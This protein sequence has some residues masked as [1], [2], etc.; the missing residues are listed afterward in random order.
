MKPGADF[1]AYANGGWMKSVEIPADRSSYG[2]WQVLAEQ[3]DERVAALIR[4]TAASAPADGSDAKKVADYYAGYMDESGIEARGL[5]V[6]RPTFD[7]IAAIAD[8]SLLARFLGSTLRADVDV[9]NSTNLYTDRLFGLW[10]A[11][12]LDDPAHYAPFVLQGGLGMPDRDYYLTDSPQMA[13]HRKQYQAHIA[14]VLGLCGEEDVQRKAS[15]IFALETRIAQ[16]HATR[17]QSEDV[18]RGDNHWTREQF[19]AL[20]PG[21]DWREYFKAARLDAQTQFVVWQPGAVRG[22]AAL[23]ASEPLDTWKAYLRF[24]AVDHSAEHLPK[25]FVEENFAFYG[26]ALEG[27]PQIRD[28]WKRAVLHTNFA[29]GEAVGKI[30][31]QR[32]FPPEAKARI[33]ELVRQLTSAFAL[34]I[35]TLTWMSPA[36]RVKAK[37]K[38][39]TLKVAVGYPDHWR[40]YS[41]LRISAADAFG[42]FGRAEEFEYRRNLRKLGAAVDRSE[43]VMTP[44]VINAVNLPV[45]NALNFPAGVLQPPFFDPQ[46]PDAMNYGAVGAVIGHEIS[47]SFDDQGALFD[48]TGRLQNWWTDADFSLFQ[49][50]ATRLANQ[51]D[52]YRPFPDLAVNGKQTLSENIADVGGLAAAYTAYRQSRNGKAAQVVGGLTGDQQFFLSF[53]QAWR[54]KFREPYLRQLLITDG[55]APSR[56]RAWTVRNNDAWYAA[57]GVKQADAMYLKPLDRVQIW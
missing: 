22:I 46:R 28:R 18:K 44:Q 38:L 51:Y 39:A 45:M 56:Y 36:T 23:A 48:A 34:R 40:D 26:K 8:R 16:D 43:W 20:A 33:E 50:A 14:A 6:L 17:T 52:S 12:D 29:L 41:D 37:A 30:Y 57:F 4:E 21:L 35:D 32:Y 54:E 7:R 10:V 13:E 47:H 27:T 15:A 9:L 49:A 53:A 2:V 5:T 11:Q 31:V 1:Y 3:N 24:H 42:N 25:A 19:A 55:H